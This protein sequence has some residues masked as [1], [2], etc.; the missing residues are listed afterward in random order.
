MKTNKDKTVMISQISLEEWERNFNHKVFV[1][2]E[3]SYQEFEG[4]LIWKK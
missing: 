2:C 4:G 3:S 1:G